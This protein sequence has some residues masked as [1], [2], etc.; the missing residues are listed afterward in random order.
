M[1]ERP[2]VIFNPA[3]KGEKAAPLRHRI[4]ALRPRPVL[5]LTEAPG[6]AEA[7]AE[8]A[9]EQ[10][11]EKIIAAGGDGTVNEVING[12]AE[13]RASFGLLPVGTMNVFATELGLPPGL[14]ACWKIIQTG[15][16]RTV[17]LGRANDHYFIQLAGV[18]LDAQI[19]LETERDF[20]KHFGPLSYLV[21]A[22]QIAARKPPRLTVTLANQQV[23][24]GS[25]VLIGNGR[26]YGGPFPLFKGA[27]IDD[28]LLDVLIF[29]KIGH[30]DLVRY[31]QGL[32]FGDAA[33]MKDLSYHQTRSLTVTSPDKI[34]VE[35]DGEL[36]GFAPVRF[37]LAKRGL[38]V[39]APVPKKSKGSSP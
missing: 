3:A 32:V 14:E 29:A 21:V 18:G 5:R 10:G 1:A 34:P 39:L 23:V 2:F 37:D 16:T 35:I 30:L 38:R 33:S 28:G 27:R 22:S 8:R 15:H 26:H 6:D 25:F 17:D 20:R 36:M 31:L 4:E 24:E 9:V 11:F 12:M 19:V 13:S 7:M